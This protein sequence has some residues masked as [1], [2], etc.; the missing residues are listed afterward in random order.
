MLAL[1]AGLT[2]PALARQFAAADSVVE[3]GIQAG[4]YP[5]AVL[6]VGRGAGLLY[7]RGFG[8]LTWDRST[9]VP[10]P[11]STRWDLASLTKVVATTG[12]VMRLVEQERIDLDA[13]VRRYLPRFTG[14]DRDQ[15]TVRQLL[16][17]RSGLPSYVPFFRQTAVRDS[18]I[19][20]LYHTPL[21]HPP[22]A[23]TQYSDLNFLL[24]GLLVEAVSDMPLDQYAAREVWQPAGML[25]TGFRPGLGERDR[26]APTGRWRGRPLCCTVND[27]NAALFGGVAGHAGLFATAQ[28]LARFARLWLGQGSLDGRSIFRSSTVREF[29]QPAGDRL[30]GWERANPDHRPDSAFGQMLSEQAYGHTGWT[31]TMMWID[32]GR[33][34]FLVFLTNRSYDPRV[35]DSFRALRRVRGVLADAVVQATTGP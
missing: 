14:P 28:D 25:Q 23:V 15:V 21:R 3:S 20:L 26:T 18:A 7:A 29:L 33:D 35:P 17:H 27:Q 22:G 5:G 12:A 19:T 6:L 24:L 32:P 9:A 2:R 4:V 8:H 10:S 34:L 13:P 16:E 11:D 31:G 30:L 1:I